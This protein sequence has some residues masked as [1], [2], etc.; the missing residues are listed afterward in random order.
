MVLLFLQIILTEKQI[1]T[2]KTSYKNELQKEKTNNDLSSDRFD[3]P[4]QVV[5]F[6]RYLVVKTNWPKSLSIAL[7]TGGCTFSFIF[8]VQGQAKYKSD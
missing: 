7:A 6:Y 8:M 3:D 4:S 2:K 5:F 1:E